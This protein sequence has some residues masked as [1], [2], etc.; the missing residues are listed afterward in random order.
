MVMLLWLY[1]GD[2]E[3]LKTSEASMLTVIGI[4]FLGVLVIEFLGEIV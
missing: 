3:A 4:I 1:E 2:N